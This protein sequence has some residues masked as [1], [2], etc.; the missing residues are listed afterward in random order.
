MRHIGL[1]IS[2]SDVAV[3]AGADARPFSVSKLTTTKK[4]TKQV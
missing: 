1:A 3:F 4:T 2:A